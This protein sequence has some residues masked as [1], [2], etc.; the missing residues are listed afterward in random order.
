MM[1]VYCLPLRPFARSRLFATT[2]LISLAMA[3][4]MARA[5]MDLDNDRVS[6]GWS[7]TSQ[8]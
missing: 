5:D 6:L 7:G 8:I 1:P 4:A 3:P 2:A